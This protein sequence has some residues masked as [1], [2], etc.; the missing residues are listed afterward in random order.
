[1][2]N[3]IKQVFYYTGVTVWCLAALFGLYYLIALLWALWQK[4]KYRT[5][6]YQ[7]YEYFRF[8]NRFKKWMADCKN[9]TYKDWDAMQFHRNKFDGK[10]RG[11][12]YRQRNFFKRSYIKCF[13]EILNSE[14]YKT[15]KS[16]RFSDD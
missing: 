12:E 8:R 2:I 4:Y 10:I 5:W 6:I 16:N 15:W 14:E 7:P 13:D 1:M 9:F 11:M 3:I